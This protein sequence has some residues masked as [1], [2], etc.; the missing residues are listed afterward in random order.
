MRVS[1]GGELSVAAIHEALAKSGIITSRL[2]VQ[3]L[4]CA[5][6]ADKTMRPFDQGVYR[7]APE[8]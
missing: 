8:V 7:L 1:A 4:L 6:A 5:L 3:N 2:R